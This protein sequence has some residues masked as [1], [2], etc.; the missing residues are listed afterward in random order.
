MIVTVAVQQPTYVCCECGVVTPDLEALLVRQMHGEY[1][2]DCPV[3]WDPAH[4]VIKYR[5]VGPVVL[6]VD[7]RAAYR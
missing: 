6:T 5:K 2:D 3:Y 7:G 4:E 1:D